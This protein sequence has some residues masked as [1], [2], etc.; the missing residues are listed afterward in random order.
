MIMFFLIS[1][2][3]SCTVP[4]VLNC[5]I[6]STRTVQVAQLVVVHLHT[7]LSGQI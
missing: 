6:N 7:E 1:P 2:R 4:V 5:S 3:T